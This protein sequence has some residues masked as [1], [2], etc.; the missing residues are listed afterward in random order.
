MSDVNN[1]NS[2]NPINQ[3]F[4]DK[5]DGTEGTGM[6]SFTITAQGIPPE[7]SLV[8]YKNYSGYQIVG[9]FGSTNLTIQRIK[10]DLGC[11][12]PRTLMFVPGFGIARF[13][14]LGFAIF[15]GVEDKVISEEIRPYLFPTSDYSES[16]IAAMDSTWQAIMWAGQTANPPMWCIAMPVGIS[17]G[18][19]TQIACYDLILKA[20]A[21]V[22]LPFSISTMSQFRTVSANSVTILGGFSDGCLSRW[23]AGDQLWDVGA[24]GSRSPS[25]VQWSVKLP[26]A[27]AQSADTKLNCRRLAIRGIA[28]AA[29]SPITVT[30][31]VNGVVK[32]IKQPYPIPVSGDFEVFASYMFD[33]LRFNGIISGS[34]QLELD[35]FAFHVSEKPVGAA[36]VIA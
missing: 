34:G 18:Q 3:A 36:A 13:C 33:G 4:L 19:L 16:D 20:W 31:I 26:E 15:D 9:V 32:A 5:D 10:S 21:M 14:H 17:G 29:V 23:Q 35:R 1:L 30:P 7:G 6:A 22:E 27:A 8:A 12:A 28:T 24:T 11:N 25:Q 2:W